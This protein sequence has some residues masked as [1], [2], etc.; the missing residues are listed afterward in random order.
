V[1]DCAPARV[2][3]RPPKTA[4]FA[5]RE[6]A[7]RSGGRRSSTGDRSPPVYR[8]ERPESRSFNSA[9][10]RGR[11]A[12]RANAP[13]ITRSFDRAGVIGSYPGSALVGQRATRAIGFGRQGSG[14]RVWPPGFGCQIGSVAPPRQAINW[15]R[16][17]GLRLAESADRS[18]SGVISCGLRIDPAA[19]RLRKRPAVRLDQAKLEWLAEVS[20]ASLA[21]WRANNRST[22]APGS[23]GPADRRRTSR[24]GAA[25]QSPLVLPKLVRS[26]GAGCRSHVGNECARSTQAQ[27]RWAKPD[28]RR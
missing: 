26:A 22:R 23:V 20:D 8:P 7:A 24:H 12:F 3:F 19:R 16:S 18:R 6:Q 5:R 14:T 25:R 4:S 27:P 1:G 11:I 15:S 2:E 13:Q 17:F 28:R 10:P 9:A 21:Q